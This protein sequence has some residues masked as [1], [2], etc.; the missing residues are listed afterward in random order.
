MTRILVMTDSTCDL[1]PETI[2]RYDICVVPLY[3]HIGK[4]E[5][6]DGID[7]TREQFYK[8]LPGYKNFPTT[9]VSSHHKFKA[10]Y[11]GL[12]DD[13]ATEILSIH[14]S[15]ALSAVINVA[16]LAAQETSSAAVSVFD[17]RQLSLG[18][19]FLVETAGRMASAGQAMG[20]ILKA[21]KA[22]ILRSHVFAALDTLEFLKRS[23]RMNGFMAN[24]GGLLQIKPILTMHDGIPGT[25]KVRTHKRAMARLVE[26]LEASGSLER[27]AI[28]HTHA[29]ERVAE[30]RSLAAH[31]LP[32]EEILMAYITPVIGA[33]IGPGAVGFAVVSA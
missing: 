7:I 16:R 26:M 1:P 27:L 12:S 25:E 2:A 5:Y 4:A 18:T 29:P 15:E 22:Q 17:S 30:L 21:S 3:I 20:D 33:H 28:V 31:L 11:D 24:V 14:I 10:V 23:G 9:A 13:G 6:Q 19:G 32:N 8:G